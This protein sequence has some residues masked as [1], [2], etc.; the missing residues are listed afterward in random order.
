MGICILHLT[1]TDSIALVDCLS[2]G[3]VDSKMYFY[4]ENFDSYGFLV[5]EFIEF[6]P[7]VLRLNVRS[8]ELRSLQNIVI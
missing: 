5:F 4:R 7:P 6:N 8:R 3:L 2:F 1:A